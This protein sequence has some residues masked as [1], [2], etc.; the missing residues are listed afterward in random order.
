ML[1][2]IATFCYLMGSL[3][4]AVLISRWTDLPDP[5]QEG[6]KNPG[7]SNILRLGHQRL[8]LL[9]LLGDSL[10]AIIPLSIAKSQGFNEAQ[11]AWLVVVACLG[12]I[13]PVFFH[14]R[15]GKGVATALGGLLVVSWPIACIAA[16]VWVGTFI[17]CRYAS[18]ASLIAITTTLISASLISSP[19]THMPIA[20]MAGILLARHSNNWARLLK[21]TESKIHLPDAL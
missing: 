16:A 21:G 7:A 18:L 13:F 3:S 5:R 11:L 12:H 1:L 19:T 2:L 9:V 20:F 10:K 14:L 15:G 6:S 4:F 17:L 8:A